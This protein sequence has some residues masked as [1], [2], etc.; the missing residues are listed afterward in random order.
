MKR[1][2]LMEVERV[3][4]DAALLEALRAVV[5]AINDLSS[6][7]QTGDATLENGAALV[8]VPGLQAGTRLI[9]GYVRTAGTPGEVYADS[10]E[11]D[12]ARQ[13]AVIRSTSGS[14]QSRVAW[15]A[16]TEG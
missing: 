10:A 3:R 16:V 12:V 5:R 4:G 8:T 2:V 13:R 15:I 6:R 7:V 1:Y 11:F 14:D 9:P